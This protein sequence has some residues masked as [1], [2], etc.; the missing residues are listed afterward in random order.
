MVP[1]VP[2]ALDME[3]LPSAAHKPPPASAGHGASQPASRFSNPTRSPPLQQAAHD[4]PVPVGADSSHD[5]CRSTRSS[6]SPLAMQCIASHATAHGLLEPSSSSSNR[7]MTQ[8]LHH[9]CHAFW[10]A[11]EAVSVHAPFTGGWRQRKPGR[12]LM[13]RPLPPQ[14][15]HGM[16][17]AH[18]QPTHTTPLCSSNHPTIAG[19]P[20]T[21]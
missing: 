3:G 14:P 8:A 20:C 2:S 4:C 6:P 5:S 21:L 12:R 9:A 7:H 16:G 10:F 18:L 15:T 13:T 19:C 1:S 17:Y 11:A